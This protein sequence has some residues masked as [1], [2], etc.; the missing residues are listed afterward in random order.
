MNPMPYEAIP[1]NTKG[2]RIILKKADTLMPLIDPTWF[3]PV[4]I[5]TCPVTA[6]KIAKKSIVF[7]SMS[8]LLF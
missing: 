3:S 7:G 8:N 5:S 4:F 1:L 2:L 6:A